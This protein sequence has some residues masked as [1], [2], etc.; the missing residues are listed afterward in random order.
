MKHRTRD[1]FAIELSGLQPLNWVCM[2]MGREGGGGGEEGGGEGGRGE[3]RCLEV[4][5]PKQQ[6]LKAYAPPIAG[7]VWRVA[8]P[9]AEKEKGSCQRKGSHYYGNKRVGVAYSDP[10]GVPTSTYSLSA[11]QDTLTPLRTAVKDT[12]IHRF[13]TW[14]YNTTHAQFCKC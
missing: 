5:N 3:V 12:H 4:G 7:S 13:R 1:P 6:K 2:W 9:T 8:L 10:Q 11:G 14:L